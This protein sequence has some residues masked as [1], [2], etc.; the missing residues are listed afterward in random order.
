MNATRLWA[1]RGQGPYPGHLS[2]HP[3][4]PPWGTSSIPWRQPPPRA[5]DPLGLDCLVSAASSSPAIHSVGC[6]MLHGIAD[7]TCSPKPSLSSLLWAS[8]GSW[9]PGLCPPNQRSINYINLTTLW[10][11]YIDKY[12][13][14]VIN[15]LSNFL[16]KRNREFKIKLWNFTF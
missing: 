8:P 16:R 1:S 14:Q 10:M 9:V 13:V 6:G 3:A 5:E 4:H 12:F 15:T 7:S 2:S 11:V